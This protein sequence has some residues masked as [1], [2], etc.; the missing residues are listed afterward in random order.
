MSTL[1]K[2]QSAH[3]CAYCFLPNILN[4]LIVTKIILF[5]KGKK[6]YLLRALPFSDIVFSLDRFQTLTQMLSHISVLNPP[7]HINSLH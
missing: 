6:T 1:E 7:V 2:L 4:T 5:T 3:T